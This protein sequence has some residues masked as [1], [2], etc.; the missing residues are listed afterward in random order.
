VRDSVILNDTV[1]HSGAVVDRSIVDKN[2]VIGAGAHVGDGDDNTPNRAMPEQ[3][4]TG[5]SLVGKGSVVPEGY[6][7]GRNVVVH[8]DKSPA[9]MMWGRRGDRL[10]FQ[11]KRGGHVTAPF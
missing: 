2:V 4:N 9:A 1:I 8:A 6:M 3:I 7:L 10:F 5:L 11:L